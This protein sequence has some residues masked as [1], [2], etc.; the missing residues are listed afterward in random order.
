MAGMKSRSVVAVVFPELQALDLTGPVEVFDAANRLSGR[1]EYAITVAGTRP[2]RVKTSSGLGVAIDT[3]LCDIARAPDTLVVTG[4]V[5]TASALADAE[6]VRQVKRLAKRARRVMSVCSGAFVLAE[7]GLLD[8]RRATT[9]WAWCETFAIRYPA[10]VVDPEPIYVRD[11]NVFT[12]AGV[13]AGMDLALALVEEDLGRDLALAVAR[14]LVMF[15]HRPANQTQFSAQLVS[16]LAERDA[17]REAQRLIAEEPGAT[18]TIP[19]LAAHVGM[20]ERNFARC[21]RQEVGQSPGRYVAS[22][23]IE[24]AR[25]LLEDTDRAGADIAAACGLGTAETMRRSFIRTLGCGPT[26]FRR[27]F[28]SSAA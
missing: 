13:T 15:L 28:R 1:T 24:A 9:H 26:E 7:A 16:Q 12:S 3:A 5:G 6:L 18:L 22:V 20:S 11:G 23:R 8:G 10:I 27:R 25:R 19:S 14:Q 4:G 17:L 21:F 2:R